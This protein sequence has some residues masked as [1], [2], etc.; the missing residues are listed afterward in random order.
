[1]GMDN[2]LSHPGAPQ[3]L[4]IL[5]CL[6]WGVSCRLPAE[7]IS[8]GQGPGCFYSS[9]P[10]GC[11]SASLT[12]A[13]GHKGSL[14]TY[15][16]QVAGLAGLPAKCEGFAT[17]VEPGRRA[18]KGFIPFPQWQVCP[19]LGPAPQRAASSSLLT[20]LLGS[21]HGPRGSDRRW[22]TH[23]VAVAS[24]TLCSQASQPLLS[25]RNPW[26][27]LEEMFLPAP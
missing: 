15:V 20:F 8:C 25:F 19:S 5:T 24:R 1:M 13:L 22:H 27:S 7:G 23:H 26:N 4:V 18:W 11:F 17:W 16:M 9:S 12:P 3:C 14:S 10:G 6:A 21:Q 2:W